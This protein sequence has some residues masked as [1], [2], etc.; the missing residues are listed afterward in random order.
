[1]GQDQI[2][3]ALITTG[4]SPAYN[5]PIVISVSQVHLQQFNHGI[6]KE[7][8]FKEGPVFLEAGPA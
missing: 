7:F 5:G 2:R 1:M 3:S 6:K 4:P 8:E